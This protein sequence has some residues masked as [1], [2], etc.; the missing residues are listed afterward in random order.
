MPWGGQEGSQL[1]APQ[2]PLVE[3]PERVT[4]SWGKTTGQSWRL[5]RP[6]FPSPFPGEKGC[7]KKQTSPSIQPSCKASTKAPVSAP[8]RDPGW[9]L[10]GER[11]ARDARTPGPGRNTQ[12]GAVGFGGRPGAGRRPC[13]L[14]VALHCP[15]G[16]RGVQGLGDRGAR[17]RVSPGPGVSHS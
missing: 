4:I 8:V 16:L 15:Q 2:C 3:R 17:H 13:I 7:V 5:T 11:R 14:L 10:S 12:E 9:A 6:W 1:V